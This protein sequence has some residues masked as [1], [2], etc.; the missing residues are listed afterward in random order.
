[1][2]QPSSKVTKKEQPKKQKDEKEKTVH[3]SE[4]LS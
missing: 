1:M 2:K 3:T 4:S